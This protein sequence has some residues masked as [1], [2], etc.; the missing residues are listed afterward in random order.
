MVASRLLDSVHKVFGE[1]G[2]NF[3]VD[4]ETDN[5]FC[6]RIGPRSCGRWRRRPCGKA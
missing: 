3:A 5:G 2:L 1:H 4:L 6:C